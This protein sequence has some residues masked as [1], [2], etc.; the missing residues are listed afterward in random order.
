MWAIRADKK[1][2]FSW[3]KWFALFFVA[4][5]LVALFLYGKNMGNNRSDSNPVQSEIQEDAPLSGQGADVKATNTGELP[6]LGLSPKQDKLVLA[7]L[8][9]EDRESL[10]SFQANKARIDVVSPNWFYFNRIACQPG[11]KIDQNTRD[12]LVASGVPIM[13]MLTNGDEKGW[14]K[15][16]VSAVLKD[17][18]LRNCLAE[19]LVKRI[20]D[21]GYYGLNVD[22]EEL[23]NP[24]RNYYGLFLKKLS[25][26]LHAKGKKLIVNIATEELKKNV[27]T[28]VDAADAIMVMSY[29]E[30]Y[31]TSEPGSV[32][33]FYWYIGI[34][35]AAQ[36][37][38]P[39]G[40]LIMGLP[41]YGY[42]WNIDR[43]TSK[44][45][46]FAEALTLSDARGIVPE[47]DYQTLNKHFSYQSSNGRHSV[48]F[49][50]AE[51]TWYLWR[52]IKDRNLLGAGLW[53]LGQEDRAM[54]KYLGNSKIT[55]EELGYQ[56]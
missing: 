15:A 47:R 40:K 14:R 33:G 32:A 4:I 54:W 13:P 2:G 30:H 11:I 17:E 3:L 45:L 56:D 6:S 36:N 23:D 52:S 5:G 53:R 25:D 38:I 9:Q 28:I 18:G 39:G 26:G 31:S 16:E 24:D 21:G 44:V 27:E 51:S 12:S 48:W 19:D 55:S 22:I 29:D 46:K 49:F 35:D 37:L 8:V 34:T 10:D 50:D 7:Y 20:V 41:G 43:N 42:D 1:W